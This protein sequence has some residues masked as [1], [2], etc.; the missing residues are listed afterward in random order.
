MTMTRRE[1]RILTTINHGYGWIRPDINAP[2][3]YRLCP[4]CRIKIEATL[5]GC[6]LRDDALARAI[7]KEIDSLMIEHLMTECEE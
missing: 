3:G 4:R 2:A 7:N 6:G 1:A 5:T